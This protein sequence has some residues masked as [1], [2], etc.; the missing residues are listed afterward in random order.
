V[1]E[2]GAALKGRAKHYVFISTISV[3]ASGAT[4]DADETA[5]LATTT[6]PDSEDR[7]RMGELYGPLKALSE[8]EAEKAFPGRTTV[9]RPGLIVG[10]GDL[11]DRFTYW[12]VR[13][14]RGGEVLAPG[15]PTDPVQIVDARDLSEFVIRCCE[16]TATGVYNVTGPRSTLTMSEM[17]GAIRGVLS[18]DARLTWVDAEFLAANSVR[19]WADMPVWLPPSGETAGF[20]RR[21]IARALA[22]GLTFRPLADTARATL[23]FYEQQPEDRKAQLRAGLAA[24]R[25]REVLAAWRARTKRA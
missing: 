25:E 22:K 9:I 17:L 3:Y 20:A 21:S 6:T 7:Q 4:P 10:P 5:P 23:E 1:R 14:Q 12:P 13:L 24:A 11:S 19:P 18:T 2:A 16:T 8:Q 15:T